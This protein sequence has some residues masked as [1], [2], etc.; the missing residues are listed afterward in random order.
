[1]SALP[2]GEVCDTC[3]EFVPGGNLIEHNRVANARHLV[4]AAWERKANLPALIETAEQRALATSVALSWDPE[5]LGFSVCDYCPA[6]VFEGPI[7]PTCGYDYG[8]IQEES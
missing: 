5:S 8:T 3:R 7:C 2:A 6:T 1:V 4:I